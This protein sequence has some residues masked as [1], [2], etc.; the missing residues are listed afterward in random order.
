[1]R[2]LTTKA[3][4]RHATK[5]SNFLAQLCRATKLPVWLCKLPNF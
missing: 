3:N 4:V 2:L 5:L 1:M